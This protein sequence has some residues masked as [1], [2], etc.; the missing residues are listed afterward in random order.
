[1]PWNDQSGPGGEK[2]GES[3]GSG[4]KGGGPWGGGQGGGPRPPWGQPPRGPQGGPRGPQGGPDLEEMLRQWR[5][6]L[7]GSLGGAGGGGGRGPRRAGGVSAPAI[8]GLILFFWIASGVYIVDEGEEAVITRFGAYDRSTGP[9]MHVHL[10][11]PIE[12]R[13]VVNVTG[14]RT[15]EIGF[16]GQADIP[17]EGLMITGDRNIVDIDFRVVYRI[18]DA[19]DF[20]FNVRDPAEAVRGVAESGMREV[21]GQRQLEAI[22]TRDRASVEQAVEELMQVTLDQYEVGVEVLQVELLKAAAP[23]AVIEAFDNVVR[24]GQDAEAERNRA[25]QY[26]NEVV[27]QARGRAAQIVQQAEAYKEQVVREATG[28]AERFNLVYEQYRQNPRVTR[29][30]IYLETMERV[31]RDADTRVIDGRSGVVPYL[32]LDQLQRRT[33]PSPAAP[34]ARA[35][36]P[37]GGQ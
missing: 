20:S 13:R 5:E 29:E 34:A 9:G 12:A 33:S 11:L 6:R 17:D 36:A 25:E 19:R 32:P 24:A 10:P 4:S 18:A 14:Q 30:R 22:I 26:R 16:D 15:L 28:E 37:Q 8:I 23:P 21:I 2:G 27:P 3:K 35:P 7:G 1:M 31:Y